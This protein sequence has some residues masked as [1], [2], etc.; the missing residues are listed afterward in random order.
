MQRYACFPEVGFQ[1][2]HR[3]PQNLLIRPGRPLD[4]S[5]RRIGAPAGGEKFLRRVPGQRGAEKQRHCA[6]MLRQRPQLLAL[7]HRRTP[8]GAGQNHRLRQ[9]R[10]C[11]LSAKRRR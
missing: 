6:M 7:R 2:L 3:R 10:H 8:F 1:P 9:L 4:D 5:H 11:Q